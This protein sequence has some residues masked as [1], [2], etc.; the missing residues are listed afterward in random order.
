MSVK[1]RIS[2][3]KESLG[4]TFGS[5]LQYGH[6]NVGKEKIY[7]IRNK[8]FFQ[9]L[10][11][12]LITSISKQML[13]LQNRQYT[14]HSLHDISHHTTPH[15]TAHATPMAHYTP[16]SLHPTHTKQHST[17]LSS[18]A[19]RQFTTSDKPD[20]TSKLI[21][22]PGRGPGP[23]AGFKP[24]SDGRKGREKGGGRDKERNG[25]KG[26]SGERTGESRGKRMGGGMKERNG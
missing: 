20:R 11:R 8:A 18:S 10:L 5:I 21:L 7:F 19:L 6:V 16:Q 22:T 17:H 15:H 12:I 3:D 23:V 1:I 24:P 26:G 14:P 9:T 4:S 25:G 13:Q 2:L